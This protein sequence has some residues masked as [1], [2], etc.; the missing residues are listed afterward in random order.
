MTSECHEMFITIA[1]VEFIEKSERGEE[2]RKEGGKDAAAEK[3]QR[4]N[5]Y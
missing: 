1:G 4:K 3:K 5:K 2:G